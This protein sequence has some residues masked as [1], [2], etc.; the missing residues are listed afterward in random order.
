MGA[1]SQRVA[2]VVP[3]SAPWSSALSLH[4]VVHEHVADRRRWTRGRVVCTG[5]RGVAGGRGC[6]GRRRA[7]RGRRATAG[8]GRRREAAAPARGG[9]AA[10]HPQA[11]AREAAD[12]DS[13]RAVS[14]REGYPRSELRK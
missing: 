7:A 10:E 11:A 1:N 8:G 5:R 12:W 6:D 13:A 14:Q 2:V 3:R 9:R 4:R